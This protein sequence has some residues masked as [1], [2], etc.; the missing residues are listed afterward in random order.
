MHLIRSLKSSKTPRR[1]PV[2]L[3]KNWDAY[4]PST[5]TLTSERSE[6]ASVVDS[7]R[8]DPDPL[9]FAYREGGISDNEEDVEHAALTTAEPLKHARKVSTKFIVFPFGTEYVR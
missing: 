2:G 4:E 5:D 1:A 7:M 8:S 3:I 9:D 6:V